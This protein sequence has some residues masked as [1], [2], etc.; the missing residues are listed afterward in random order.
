MRRTW[1]QKYLQILICQTTG[2]LSTLCQSTLWANLLSFH[3]WG[4]TSHNFCQPLVS[5]TQGKSAL[6]WW[7]AA[8]LAAGLLDADSKH[9]P[10]MVTIQ[11]PFPLTKREELNPKWRLC[12]ILSI[13]CV[14]LTKIWIHPNNHQLR[15]TSKNLQSSK[16]I[17]IYHKRIILL[18]L[19]KAGIVLL[20]FE[21]WTSNSSQYIV[22]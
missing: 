12:E 16:F 5:M 18:L 19:G 21:L 20:F 11:K 10:G 8:A 2:E 17:K 1:L 7:W 4:S 9:H 15:L 14:M 6:W 13:S 22:L 3:S